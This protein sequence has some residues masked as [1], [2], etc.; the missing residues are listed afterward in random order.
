MSSKTLRTISMVVF[1]LGVV[2]IVGSLA[3]WFTSRSDQNPT[4]LAEAQRLGLFVGLWPP[5]L[6][7]LS[8]QLDR[9]AK[10]R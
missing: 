8:N 7:I 10:E 3:T 6:F 9:M 1:G 4:S 2:S 5:T